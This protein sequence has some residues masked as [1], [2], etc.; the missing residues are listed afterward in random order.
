MFITLYNKCH[1]YKN[2]LKPDAPERTFTERD[3]SIKND[4]LSFIQVPI[5]LAVSDIE[6]QINNEIKIGEVVH[7]D[8]VFKPGKRLRGKWLNHKVTVWKTGNVELSTKGDYIHAYLPI[9]VRVELIPGFSRKRVAKRKPLVTEAEINVTAIATV[10]LNANWQLIADLEV[11]KY[12]WVTYPEAEILGVTIDI[13]S[14]AEKQLEKIIPRFIPRLEGKIKDKVNVKKEL[15]KVW[16][17]LQKSHRISKNPQIWLNI[18][19]FDVSVSPLQSRNDSLHLSLGVRVYAETVI[20][21]RPSRQPIKLLPPLKKMEEA[22]HRFAITLAG[23]ISYEHA[24]ELAF[25]QVKDTVFTFKDEAYKLQIKEL[26]MYPSGEELVIMLGVSGSVNGHLYLKGKPLYSPDDGNII[27]ENF[28]F[29]VQTYNFLVKIADWFA[30]GTFLDYINQHL[31]FPLDDNLDQAVDKLRELME[32]QKIGKNIVLNGELHH[33]KP[34]KVELTDNGIK[35]MV[36][37]TGNATFTILAGE[38]NPIKIKIPRK[39]GRRL[40]E[41]LG[42]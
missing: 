6:E 24:A 10:G 33:L 29:D 9:G 1:T 35:A 38:E 13:T 15:K 42:N 5:K 36:S 14:F 34:R 8:T 39:H 3:D 2:Y 4:E 21:D 41:D 11:Q 32:E 22:D 37:A 40:I 7:R 28:D 18:T 27:V 17:D 12:E 30:H 16:S 19:P 20:G 31:H 23:N 26:N 25:K